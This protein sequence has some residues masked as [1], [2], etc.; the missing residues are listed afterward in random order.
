[1]G[2]SV[3]KLRE[4]GFTMG[5]CHPTERRR[6]THGPY[7]LCPPAWGTQASQTGG[8]CGVS[9]VALTPAGHQM[10]ADFRRGLPVVTVGS[11]LLQPSG[12]QPGHRQ[13]LVRRVGLEMQPRDGLREIAYG[14]REGKTPEEVNREFHD[15]YVRW[16]ADPGWNGPTGGNEG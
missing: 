8:Y 6:L 2:E 9:D 10:A 15:E 16:L 13:A 1:M 7:P 5:P 14:Q 4:Q 11:G 12:P 3:L